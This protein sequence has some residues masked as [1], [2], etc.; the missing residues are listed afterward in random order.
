MSALVFERFLSTPEMVEA[1]GE[2][3]IVQGMLDFEAALARAQAAAGVIPASAGAAIASACRAEGFDLNA[4]VAASSV[5][6][7]LA[8]PLVEQLTVAVAQRDAEAAG[9][10]HWGSTSQDVIDTAMVLAT[11]RALALID[12]RLCDLINAL[13]GL[14]HRHGDVPLLGRS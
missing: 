7:T 6:G 12:V 3:A 11:R 2:V 1:F 4:I 8:I 10:V 14:A 13:F 5:A 9:Y